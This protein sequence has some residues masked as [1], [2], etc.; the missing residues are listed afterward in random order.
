MNQPLPKKRILF[1]DDEPNVLQALRRMLRGKRSVWDMAFIESGQKALDSLSHIHVDIVVSDLWMPYMDG[2][3]LLS[4]IRRRHPHI[5]RILFSG[6]SDMDVGVK[7]V[8]LAHQFLPKPC[9]S[10]TLKRVLSQAC[11]LSDLVA[12][13]PI[14]KVLAQ[15]KTLPSQPEVYAKLVAVLNSSVAST[16]DVGEIIAHEPAMTAKIL[17]LVNSAFFGVSRTVT[18]PVDA[19][20]MLG[21]ETIKVLVLTYHVF[22]QFDD[23]V[24]RMFPLEWLWSHSIMVGMLAREI[25]QREGLGNEAMESAL[26]AGLLHDIGKLVL[27]LNFPEQYK[28]VVRLV[29][30]KHFPYWTAEQTVFRTSHAEVGAYLLGIWGLP[31]TMVESITFHHNPKRCRE[32]GFGP[33]TAVHVADCIE[34]FKFA[35]ERT[36]GNFQIA[37]DYLERI[38]VESKLSSW[39]EIGDEVLRAAESEAFTS[40]P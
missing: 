21:L 14:R 29:E 12:S 18:N 35:G 15:V 34:H 9:D 36:V 22:A 32:T 5:V 31:H 25:C 40:F 38:G 33:L 3:A 4:E 11:A 19:V 10:E 20:K 8:D 16:Q 26:I 37:E 24:L 39:Y 27:G 1:V 2:A 13:E 6:Q 17:Q 30:E 23:T 7:F 28:K